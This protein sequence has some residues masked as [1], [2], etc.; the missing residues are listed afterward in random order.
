MCPYCETPVEPVAVELPQLD[1]EHDRAAAAE[2]E[3]E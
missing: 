1:A 3:R 2:R